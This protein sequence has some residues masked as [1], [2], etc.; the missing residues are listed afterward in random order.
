MTTENTTLDHIL[1]EITA[2]RSDMRVAMEKLV[3]YETTA[4][5]A[6]SALARAFTE[7]KELSLRVA[8]IEAQMPM[9]NLAKTAVF[10]FITV[11]MGALLS[12][13]FVLVI[14]PSQVVNNDFSPPRQQQQSPEKF[15]RAA[16]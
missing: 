15:P 13:V 8:K 4:T 10:A 5:F 3:R 9:N 6:D 16:P 12:A 1:T 2:L 7:S 14:R 11:A